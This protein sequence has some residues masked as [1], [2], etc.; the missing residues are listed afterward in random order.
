MLCRTL[1]LALLLAIPAAAADPDPLEQAILGLHYRI[2]ARTPME[3]TDWEKSTFQMQAKRSL[4]IKSV[5]P[6]PK[7]KET[8][9]RFVVIDETYADAE[10][11]AARV[12]RLMERPPGLVGEE[13]LLFPLRKGLAH[14]SRVLVVT[15]DAV[16]FEPELSRF[17]QALQTALSAP[18]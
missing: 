10:H 18:P 14:G 5:A 17:V 1:A 4:R 16:L 2:L 3:P 8:Y 7:S 12:Q 15:T 9:A 6:L 13:E 11:A